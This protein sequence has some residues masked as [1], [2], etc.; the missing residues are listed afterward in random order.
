MFERYI[1]KDSSNETKWKKSILNP[2]LINSTGM[3][4]YEQLIILI[5]HSN[6]DILNIED[7]IIC[8]KN[9]SKKKKEISD[10]LSSLN[11]SSA[12]FYW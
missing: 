11:I 6:Y 4:L 3:I 5:N 1:T 2:K 9:I 7:F 12:I 10:E 8:A